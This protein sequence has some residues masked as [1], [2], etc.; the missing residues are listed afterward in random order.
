MVR[1]VFLGLAV[2]CG[3]WCCIAGAQ[4]QRSMVFETE[5]LDGTELVLS[6]DDQ[7]FGASSYDGSLVFSGTMTS[8]DGAWYEITIATNTGFLTN[9][10]Q[11]S[12]TTIS[13]PSDAIGFSH[14]SEWI[15]VTQS[16][17]TATG[18]ISETQVV[19]ENVEAWLTVDGDYADLETGSLELALAQ[20]LV[21]LVTSSAGGPTTGGVMNLSSC[22]IAAEDT[23]GEDCVKSV[24]FTITYNE[25]GDVASTSCSFE[26]K[27]P[28]P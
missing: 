5:Y 9:G 24:T 10:T 14:D 19:S 11:V 1:N 18:S 28:C 23:C 4:A 8:A 3:S 20:S 2:T 27:D 12:N 25:D 21:S 15:A 7:D 13:S 17:S 26:C 16:Q 6:L 22:T